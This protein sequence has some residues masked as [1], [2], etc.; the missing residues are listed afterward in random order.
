MHHKAKVLSSHTGYISSIDSMDIGQVA[1]LLGAG[2]NTV[3]ESVDFSAGIWF[4]QRPGMFVK[5]GDLLAMV[6]AERDTVL[7]DAVS[8]VQDAFRFS[9]EVVTLPPLIQY[10]VTKNSVE[11]FDQSILAV[12]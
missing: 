1:V 9:K 7:N 5:E 6:F 12:N 3:E 10:F 8:R 4:L 11:E 2:R